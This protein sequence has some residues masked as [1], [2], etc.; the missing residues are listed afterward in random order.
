MKPGRG[1][2]TVR[3]RTPENGP[4]ASPSREILARLMACRGS[5]ASKLITAMTTSNCFED[6]A[7]SRLSS[8][9]MW[10]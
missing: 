3:R 2:T 6:E 9:P 10:I 1:R 8:C 7:E 5:V 4:R